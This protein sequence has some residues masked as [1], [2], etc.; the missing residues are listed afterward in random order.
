MLFLCENKKKSSLF[1]NLPKGMGARVRWAEDSMVIYSLPNRHSPLIM[2]G[3]KQ[4]CRQ[5][6]LVSK[7]GFGQRETSFF[8]F[9]VPFSRTGTEIGLFKP[10]FEA[11]AFRNTSTHF[12]LNKSASQSGKKTNLIDWKLWTNTWRQQT[13]PHFW[14]YFGIH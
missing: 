13:H 5:A 14:D 12:T 1:L 6:I 9:K 8:F 7:A 3:C 4:S 2:W 10:E 11:P